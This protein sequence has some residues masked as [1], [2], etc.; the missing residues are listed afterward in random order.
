MT[1]RRAIERLLATVRLAGVLFAIFE[2]GFLTTDF[3]RG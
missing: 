3:P 1:D 2:I